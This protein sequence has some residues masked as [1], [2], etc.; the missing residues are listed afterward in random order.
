MQSTMPYEYLFNAWVTKAVPVYV[1]P[2]QG[3]LPPKILECKRLWDRR[4]DSGL[5]TKRECLFFKTAIEKFLRAEMDTSHH[6]AAGLERAAFGASTVSADSVSVDQ[7]DF[8]HGMLPIISASAVFSLTFTA[9][10]T[11][12]PELWDW[13]EK[14]GLLIT[15]VSWSYCFELDNSEGPVYADMS[16]GETNMDLAFY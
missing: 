4:G 16:T 11:S 8:S 1:G 9:P 3:G 15:S 13:E 7:F 2:E 14:H 10:F 12:L 5:W 6:E